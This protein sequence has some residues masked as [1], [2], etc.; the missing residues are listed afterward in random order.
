MCDFAGQLTAW[1]DGELD[2]A[3]AAGVESHLQ[4]CGQCHE[5]LEACRRAVSAFEAYCVAYAD[6]GLA[7]RPERKLPRRVL[8]VS[9][10]GALAAVVATLLLLMPSPQTPAASFGSAPAIRSAPTD[11]QPVSGTQMAQAQDSN[12]SPSGLALEIAIPGEDMAPPGALPEGLGFT[13]DI[14][15]APDGSAQQI[16]VRPQL[17]EFERRPNRP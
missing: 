13:A 16:Q 12:F 4:M 14:M 17:T 9:A 15:F 11:D 10:A 6:A 5:R 7:S 3:E 1:L 2:A 8:A